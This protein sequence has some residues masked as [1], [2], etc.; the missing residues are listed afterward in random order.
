MHLHEVDIAPPDYK[1]PVQMLRNIADQI[2]QGDWPNVS[3]IVVTLMCDSG[4]ETF[5]GGRDSGMEHC[6]FV[7]G[8][9]H[10]QLL[11]IPHGAL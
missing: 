10:V 9:A 5:G 8:A 7:L 11:S 1:D 2:E 6:A 3:T 4:H